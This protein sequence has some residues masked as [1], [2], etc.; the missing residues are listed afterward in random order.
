[1]YFFFKDC[2]VHGSFTFFDD[3]NAT[4]K[5]TFFGDEKFWLFFFS[6]LTRLSEKI[7]NDFLFVDT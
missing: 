1:M 5:R 7:C 3:T 4:I 2:L 6:V